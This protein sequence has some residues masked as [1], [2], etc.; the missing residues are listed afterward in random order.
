MKIACSAHEI[1]MCFQRVAEMFFRNG[2]VVADAT[3]LHRDLCLQLTHALV[4][5]VR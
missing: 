5:L 1:S 2:R 3:G 4:Q